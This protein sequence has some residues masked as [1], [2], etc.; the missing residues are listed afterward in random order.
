ME[1]AGIKLL[2]LPLFDGK[3][4]KF[5]VWWTQL[6]AYAGVFGFLAALQPGGEMDMPLTERTIIDEM[7][8]DGKKQAHAK[9]RNETAVANLTMLFTTDG[10]MAIIHKS[11]PRSWP[12][13]LA[14]EIT[15]GWK[16][17]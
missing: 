4:E 1:S 7:T 8:K 14:H 6:E 2:R 12:N 16:K 5:Q 11:K 15:R 9:K 10:T 3:Q 13:G 17:K